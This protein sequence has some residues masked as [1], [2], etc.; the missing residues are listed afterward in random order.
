[1]SCSCFGAFS[2]QKKYDNRAIQSTQGQEGKC[3]IT[4]LHSKLH[5]HCKFGSYNL[6]N[7]HRSGLHPF[8]D[9]LGASQFYLE[10]IIQVVYMLL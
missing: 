8:N 6:K 2:G 10:C 9:F 5:F 3:F 1:M 4:V 7:S